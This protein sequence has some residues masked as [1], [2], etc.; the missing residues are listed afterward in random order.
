MQIHF[1]LFRY[2]V[3][4]NTDPYLSGRFVDA[5]FPIKGS[6][7]RVRKTLLLKENMK[8]RIR[9]YHC[10]HYMGTH[11]YVCITQQR[12]A[13]VHNSCKYVELENPRGTT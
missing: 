9:Y 12:N 10:I 4:N 7:H 11:S 2:Y 1:I 13:R 6:P 5:P 8:W 3:L